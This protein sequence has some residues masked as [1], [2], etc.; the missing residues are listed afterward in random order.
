MLNKSYLKIKK[1]NKKKMFKQFNDL[2]STFLAKMEKTE[3]EVAYAKGGTLPRESKVKLY[4]QQFALVQGMNSKKPVEMFMEN[5][6]PFGEKILSRDEMF[7]KQDEFVG[8]AESI[9]GK[10][11]L[12][13]YWDALN[14]NTK[15]SIWEYMQG[16]YILGMA[17]MNQQEELQRL[18]KKTGFKG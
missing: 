3:E 1:D 6:T 13:Q 5:M 8:A 7:F 12:I 11:G 18:I 10:I 16:L 4:R 2:A 17:S 9:S 15:N 14:D